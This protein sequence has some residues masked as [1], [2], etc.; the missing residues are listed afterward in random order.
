MDHGK[1]AREAKDILDRLTL[2]N[3]DGNHYAWK[4]T[5]VQ[6]AGKRAENSKNG[7][8]DGY[9]ISDPFVFVF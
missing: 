1:L 3:I 5:A 6:L 9:M 7:D 2:I 8:G 4:G